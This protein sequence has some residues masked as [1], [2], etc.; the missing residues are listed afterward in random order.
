MER[1]KYIV[2]AGLLSDIRGDYFGCNEKETLCMKSLRRLATNTLELKAV[3]M[4]CKQLP[5]SATKTERLIGG[6]PGLKS[7]PLVMIDDGSHAE[8]VYESRCNNCYELPE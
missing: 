1:K 6:K 4:N 3:C 8:V 5:P 7:D 2:A